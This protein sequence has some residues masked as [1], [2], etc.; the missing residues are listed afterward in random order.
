MSGL[1]NLECERYLLGILMDSS[2]S[3][4]RLLTSLDRMDFTAN[5]NQRLFGCVMSLYAGGLA[6]DLMS[7][8]DRLTKTGELAAVGG[9]SYLSSLSEGMP[10]II[11]PDS[12]LRIVKNYRSLRDIRAVGREIERRAIEQLDDPQDIVRESIASL[13]KSRQQLGN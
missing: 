6:S 3:R 11:N 2:A 8:A 1:S 13:E 7:V 5:P 10:V 12:Y 9:M 4:D